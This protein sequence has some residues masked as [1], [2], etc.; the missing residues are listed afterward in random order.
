[1][2]KAVYNSS[3]AQK[4][5][6]KRM[7][8]FIFLKYSDENLAALAAAN[9]S[10]DMQGTHKLCSSNSNESSLLLSIYYVSELFRVLLF[11]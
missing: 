7:I 5:V 4:A 1:M 11:C 8:A 9:Q 2:S 6:P 3:K 10:R